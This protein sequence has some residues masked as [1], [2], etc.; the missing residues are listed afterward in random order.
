M[1]AIERSWSP[2]LSHQAHEKSSPLGR[3][4]GISLGRCSLCLMT[5]PLMVPFDDVPPSEL[6]V[7]LRV[8]DNT[9]ARRAGRGRADIF[10]SLALA[11]PVLR[12]TGSARD[13][14]VA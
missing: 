5:R 3:A 12:K 1:C 7:W 4:T 10:R 8:L 6:V 9:F 2:A 11:T 14:V 13:I